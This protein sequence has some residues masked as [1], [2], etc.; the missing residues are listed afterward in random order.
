M[1]ASESSLRSYRSATCPAYSDAAM[2][3][4][5]SAR[6]TKP[7][8]SGSWVMSYT[9]HATTVA[10]IMVPSVIATRLAT[11]QRKSGFRSETYGSSRS[12]IGC[13]HGQRGT[14]AGW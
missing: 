7:R 10:W 14:G 1:A 6:P 3:G 8:E 9:C 11:Y 2:N 13:F 4:S 12:A 5:A